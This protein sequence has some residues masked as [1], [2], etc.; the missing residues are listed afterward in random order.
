VRI[1]VTT[2]CLL[3]VVEKKLEERV[4]VD[5]RCWIDVQVLK[6]HERANR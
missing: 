5:S 1:V 6:I 4:L 3:V 2:V